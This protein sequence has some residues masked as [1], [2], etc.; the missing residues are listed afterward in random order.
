METEY[1]AIELD[2]AELRSSEQGGFI[3]EIAGYAV[4]W[5]TPSTNLPFTEVIQSGALNDVNT[6]KTLALFNHDFANVLGRVDAGT[7]KLTV[8]K[9]G[10]HFV[11]QIPDTTLGHDVYTQIKNGNLKGLSFRFTVA[12]DGEYWKQLNGKPTRVISKIAT[13][14]EISIVSIPAY[15]DTSIEVTRS[16]KEFTEKQNYKAKALIA[17]ATYEDMD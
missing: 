1:R 14:R 7:L 2:N 13:M 17:L 6:S 16:F 4:V 8:D 3:G 9:T 5:N 15:D 11:L 12:P 10:L